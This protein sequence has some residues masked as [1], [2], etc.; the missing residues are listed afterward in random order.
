MTDFYYPIV[1]WQFWGRA[2]EASWTEK[3]RA[4]FPFVLLPGARANSA[5]LIRAFQV[6]SEIVLVDEFPADVQR[7]WFCA[8]WLQSERAIESKSSCLR[9]GN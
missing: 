3:V 4:L 5:S 2:A 1:V 7:P 8:E 9:A 6:Q